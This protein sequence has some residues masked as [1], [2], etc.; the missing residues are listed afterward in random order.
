MKVKDVRV[1]GGTPRV[2]RSACVSPEVSR[3]S[4]WE[5]QRE[6]PAWRTVPFGTI[7]PSERSRCEVRGWVS[8]RNTEFYTEREI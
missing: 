6:S 3:H 5:P 1:L 2:W 4:L 8:V 7:V